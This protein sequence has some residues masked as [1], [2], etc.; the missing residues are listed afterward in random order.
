MYFF[1]YIVVRDIAFYLLRCKGHDDT[2]IDP[3]QNLLLL[4][5]QAEIYW[6]TL[7]DSFL[8]RQQMFILEKSTIQSIV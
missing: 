4:V 8:F 6:G 3:C 5:V 7:L 2:K 1:K